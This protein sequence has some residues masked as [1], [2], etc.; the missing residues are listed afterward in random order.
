MPSFPEPNSVSDIGDLITYSNTV[1]DGLY[2][3]L[4]LISL[5]FVVL[6][7][8]YLRGDEIENSFLAAG[9][10]T[11]FASIFLRLGGWVG[12]TSLFIAIVLAVLPIIWMLW[13]RK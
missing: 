7:Y 11:A 6:I 8:I 13:K 5:Y 12:D 4:V 2:G 1:T 9:I 10:I 3:S